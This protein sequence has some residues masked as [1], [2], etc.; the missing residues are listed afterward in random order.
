M[1]DPFAEQS[2]VPEEFSTG[3]APLTVK[4]CMFHEDVWSMRLTGCLKM[5]LRQSFK[6]KMTGKLGL[7]F[8]SQQMAYT[9]VDV[10]LCHCYPFR[11]A[12]DITIKNS[13]IVLASDTEVQHE[14][15]ESGSEI[16]CGRGDCNHYA[17]FSG[18]GDINVFKAGTSSAVSVQGQLMLDEE[19]S[20]AVAQPARPASPLQSLQ[21]TPPKAG[22][23]RCAV[24][25]NKVSSAQ[26]ELLQLQAS[27]MLLT[28]NLLVRKVKTDIENAHKITSLTCY[29]V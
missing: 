25:E 5:V 14:K 3:G 19:E 20:S 11:G 9:G 24:V 8:A 21:T 4:G 6:V 10:S 26:T 27:M 29:G 15:P 16:S 22:E 17:P 12:P 18:G 1:Q 2:T 23:E 7:Q 28:S 13:P